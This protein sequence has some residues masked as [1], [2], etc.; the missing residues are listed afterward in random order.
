MSMAKM[1]LS[2]PRALASAPLKTRVFPRT[3]T[4]PWKVY[5]VRSARFIGYPLKFRD[6]RDLIIRDTVSCC[7]TWVRPENPSG[8]A[9]GMK[10]SSDSLESWLSSIE[11]R[12]DRGDRTGELDG[13]AIETRRRWLLDVSYYNTRGCRN[14]KNNFL[15]LIYGCKVKWIYTFTPLGCVYYPCTNSY[16]DQVFLR[17][18]FQQVPQFGCITRKHRN[19]EEKQFNCIK[20]NGELTIRT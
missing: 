11:A 18:T 13:F 14:E 3:L 19:F 20:F 6:K 2:F 16:R 1:T 5:R 10:L 4:I 9:S 17:L 7:C 12:R 15:I 8:C